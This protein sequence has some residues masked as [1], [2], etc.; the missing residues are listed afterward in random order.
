MK[1]VE[2]QPNRLRRTVARPQVVRRPSR[3]PERALVSGPSFASLR[4]AWPRSCRVRIGG[5]ARCPLSAE[6]RLSSKRTCRRPADRTTKFPAQANSGGRSGPGRRNA[7]NGRNIARRSLVSGL[8][9][10]GGDVMRVATDR[11]RSERPRYEVFGMD[12]EQ[13]ATALPAGRRSRRPGRGPE[14]R[15]EAS[16]RSPADGSRPEA[17]P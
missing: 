16:G 12:R 17:T 14:E 9:I 4:A 8:A 15:I 5:D 13:R 1:R 6:R 3:G 11:R 2:A 10:A 7:L